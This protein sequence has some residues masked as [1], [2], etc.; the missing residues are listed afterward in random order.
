MSTIGLKPCAANQILQYSG[1]AWNCASAGTG[2]ITVLTAGSDLTGGDTSGNITLNLDTTKVPRL[3]VDNNFTGVN[4]FGQEAQFNLPAVFGSNVFVGGN[5]SI[6]SNANEPLIV[7]GTANNTQGIQ[8][9]HRRH[10]LSRHTAGYR[11]E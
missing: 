7:Q 4:I 2:T 10:V 11:D 9:R 1:T 6:T 8:T 5:M 3:V